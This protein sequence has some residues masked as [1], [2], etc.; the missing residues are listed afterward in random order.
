MA[1][2]DN[3]DRN[4]SILDVILERTSNI[5]RASNTTSIKQALKAAIKEQS[6]F[7]AE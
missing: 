5:E 3:K 7:E 1:A 6:R 4:E 2:N